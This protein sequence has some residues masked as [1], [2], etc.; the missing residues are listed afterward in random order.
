MEALDSQQLVNLSA[1]MIHHMSRVVNASHMEQGIPYGYFLSKVFIA[2]E[3]PCGKGH[4]CN[5]K[6]MIRE[7]TLV[8]C[9]F[10]E[11]GSQCRWSVASLVVELQNAQARIANLEGHA[12]VLQPKYEHVRAQRLDEQLVLGKHFDQML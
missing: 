2:F 6:E 8:E 10:G 4:V 3:I 12:Y 11:P 9:G 7:H 5:R 1:L